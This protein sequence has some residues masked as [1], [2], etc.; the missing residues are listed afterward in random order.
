L[1]VRLEPLFG[2]SS[3]TPVRRAFESPMAIAC[4]AERAP[5]L[6]SRM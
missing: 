3:A 1:P 4:L 6:L 5:W 2:G